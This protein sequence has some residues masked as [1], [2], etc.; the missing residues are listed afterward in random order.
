[1]L[2]FTHLE[3]YRENNRIEAKK[4]LGGLPHSIWETYSAFANTLGGIILLGV[5][6]RQDTTF[7]TVDLPDPE[8]LMQEFWRLV[9]DPNKASANILTSEDVYMQKVNGNRIVVIH[10]P[11]ADRFHRPVYVEGNPLTGTYRRNGE[12]DYRCT[13]EEYLAMVRDADSMAQDMYVLE[14]MDLSVFHKKSIQDYRKRMQAI[15]PQH[16]WETLDDE[17]FLVRLGA[18]ALGK[19]GQRHPTSAGL[20]MFGNE[21]EILREFPHYFLDY[22]EYDED[23]EQWVYRIVSSSGDWSGNVYDFFWQVY[24]RLIEDM[25]VTAHQ[26]AVRQTMREALVNCLVNADYYGRQGIVVINRQDGITMSNP[27]RFRIEMDAAKSGGISDPRNAMLLRMFSLLGIGARAGSGIPNI[28]SVWNQQGWHEPVITESF[29]PDRITLSLSWKK[30]KNRGESRH[31]K[32]T[33]AM[34]HAIYRLKII[35]YL[36]DHTGGKTAEI[37][38]NLQLKQ[39]QTRKYLKELIQEEIVVAEGNGRSRIYRLKR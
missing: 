5:V 15:R 17:N 20:L 26:E 11:R 21:Y 37:A 14:N 16:T 12:G 25:E 22:Q 32:T 10:V 4:A 9:N 36:T 31:S 39:S 8:G 33:Y 6:E 24:D 35:E 34:R 7:D 19:D 38:E 28:L 27:G 2:D 3:E 1:M 23:S 29:G 13:R 18:V 30:S